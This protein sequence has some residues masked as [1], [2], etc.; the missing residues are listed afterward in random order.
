MRVSGPAVWK[1]MA[2]A[3]LFIGLLVLMVGAGVYFVRSNWIAEAERVSG[4]VVAL[5]PRRLGFSPT[6]EFWPTD[7]DLAVQFT[8][9][10]SNNPPAYDIGD[11]VPVLFQAADPSGA[12]IDSHIGLWWPAYALGGF[13]ILF[14]VL[15]IAA[16]V[17]AFVISRPLR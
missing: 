17:V 4:E 15:G 11:A 16:R 6:V 2:F 12:V 13:G 9:S 10:W 1:G 3:G 8:P 5:E 14:C 7:A